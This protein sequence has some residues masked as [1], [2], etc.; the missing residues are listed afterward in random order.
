MAKRDYYEVLGLQKGATTDEIK[1]AYRKQA[2]K[3]HP[4]KWS[5]ATEEEQK[6]AEK[7]FKEVGEAYA[8]LSDEQKRAR[9]DQFGHAGVN[10]NFGG[11]GNSGG[12]DFNGAD[13]DPFDIFNAFFGG[14]ARTSRTRNGRTTYTYTTSGNP[15]GRFGGF[16]G[17]NGFGGDDSDFN[18]FQQEVKGQDLN[19]T[20]RV[21]LDDVMNGVDKQVKIKHSVADATGN[22]RQVEDIIPIHLPK[23]VMEG[24]KFKA[25]GKGNAAPGGK[26]VPGDLIVNIEEIQHPELLRDHEDLVYNC[27]ISFPTAAL[28]GPVEIPTLNG[29]V[30]INIAAGTQPGKMLRLKG[31]G[32]PSKDTGNLGDLI[33]N[34]LVYVPEKLT[35]D[36]RKAIEKLSNG[37]NCSPTEEKRQSLFSR[38]KYFFTKQE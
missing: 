12:F 3:W 29:R 20:L 27:L 15:F 7:N 18:P 34:I 24:Q 37:K 2:L 14:G 33:V 25:K 36:E 23:G 1:K 38:I 6:T 4:D 19:I 32:L 31:K 5:Q 16:S 17:F 22:V 10:G 9:Y 28:G 11:G 30:R 8:V 26:G 13:F 21:T 35:S